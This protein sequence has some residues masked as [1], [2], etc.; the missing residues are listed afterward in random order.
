MPSR[1]TEVE[2]LDLIF[3]LDLSTG[4]CDAKECKPF[5]LQDDNARE[6]KYFWMCK[7]MTLDSQ[8]SAT[9]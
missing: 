8:G 1:Y 6:T 4:I 5:S 2:L 3:N 9:T 7:Y